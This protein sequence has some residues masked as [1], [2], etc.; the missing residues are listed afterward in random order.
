MSIVLFWPP[1][2]YEK[3]LEYDIPSLSMASLSKTLE[4]NNFEVYIFDANF[5]FKSE[6]ICE[7]P[8]EILFK[9]I[10]IIEEIN[11]EILGIGSWTL[12]MPFIA[13]FL[14]KFKERNPE[15]QIILGG[16][17]PT[18]LPGETLEK[19]PSVDFL[20]RGEGEYT[21]LE[22]CK[23]LNGKS[24]K[25]L[26]SIQGISYKNKKSG[27]IIHNKK[28]DLCK[29]DDLPLVDFENYI[30]IEKIRKKIKPILMNSR[31]CIY[32]CNFCSIKGI[33]PYYRFFSSDKTIEQIKRL[34][35]LYDIDRINFVDDNFFINPKRTRKLLENINGSFP[36]LKVGGDMRVENFSLEFMKK[37][38]NR[39]MDYFFIGID[40]IIPETLIFYGKTLKPLKYIQ[41]VKKIINYIKKSDTHLDMGYILGAPN[42]IMSSFFETREFFRKIQKFKNIRIIPTIITVYPGTTLWRNYKEGKLKVYYIKNHLEISSFSGPYSEK[43][44]KSISMVPTYYRIKNNVLNKMQLER[45]LYKTVFVVFGDQLKNWND[46]FTPIL[47]Q[48]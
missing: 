19:I 39:N 34:L 13:D 2:N 38:K 5:H 32:S 28:R 7:K 44:S 27:K 24:S 40:S 23:Y 25:K 3:G 15:I 37:M 33:W 8:R 35:D 36:D 45:E 29:L 12:S 14:I 9:C 48:N 6:E 47:Y 46:D 10:K 22:L 43:Y 16:Y 26:A 17:N 4:E 11:P 42:E 41:K 1:M 21:L 20:V 30:N 18:F 31:G